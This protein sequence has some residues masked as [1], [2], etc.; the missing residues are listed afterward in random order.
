MLNSLKR[1]HPVRRAPFGFIAVVIS[2]AACTQIPPSSAARPPNLR[3][4]ADNSEEAAMSMKAVVVA[5]SIAIATSASA[6][7]GTQT[8]QG[9]AQPAHSDEIVMMRMEIAAANKKYGQKVAAAKKAFDHKKAEA[10]KERD[11]AIAAAH[12]G[13][14]GQ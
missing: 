12:N 5:V 11:A 13:V 7:T 10:T 9:T 8:D 4:E 6:Q 14:S 2:C 3:Q 1:S